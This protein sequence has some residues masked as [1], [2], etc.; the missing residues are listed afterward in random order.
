MSPPNSTPAAEGYPKN[1]RW[2]AL[3]ALGLAWPALTAPETPRPASVRQPKS[4]R[5]LDRYGDPLPPGA[6]ARMGTTFFRHS[7]WTADAVFSPDGKA[8]IS[9]GGDGQVRLWSVATGKERAHFAVNPQ[10]VEGLALSPDG[11]TLAGIDTSS[12]AY[13]WQV[14]TGKELCRVKK[15]NS[16]NTRIAFTPKGKPVAMS[17]QGEDKLLLWEMATGKVLHRIQGIPQWAV[18]SPGAEIV[19]EKRNGTLDLRSVAT[20]RELRSIITGQEIVQRLAFSQDGKTLASSDADRVV[21]IW[22]IS[23]AKK[24]G[25]LPR[26]KGGISSL[27]FAPN[28]K[29]L[30][31]ATGVTRAELSNRPR[32]TTLSFWNWR[33]GKLFRRFQAHEEGAAHLTLSRDGKLLAVM[34]ESP[35]RRLWDLA[36]GKELFP[37]PGNFS[38]VTAPA[39][40]PDSKLLASAGRGHTVRLWQTGTGKQVA[41]LPGHGPGGTV[42]AF[43][44]NGKTLATAGREKT[45]RLWNVTKKKVILRLRGH[46]GG[47]SAL[48]F[49]PDGKQLVSGGDYSI[50]LWSLATAKQLRRFWIISGRYSFAVWF[51]AFTPDGKQVVSL[52]DRCIYVWDLTEGHSLWN[53]GPFHFIALSP[54]GK[55]VGGVAYNGVIF[56]DTGTGK[57]TGRLGDEETGG[58]PKKG[59]KMF[60]FSP[61]GKMVATIGRDYRIRF[62]E[63]ISGK[64]IARLRG[65]PFGASCLCFSPDG[66]TL[67]TGF[68]DSTILEWDVNQVLLGKRRGASRLSPAGLKKLWDD[69]AGEEVPE[70]FQALATLVAAPKTAVPFLREQLFKAHKNILRQIAD[71]DSPRYGTRRKA[72]QELKRLGP[73]AEPFLRKELDGTPSLEVR[74]RVERLLKKLRDPL[75]TPHG[76]RLL[77][78]ITVLERIGSPAARKVLKKLTLAAPGD[79]LRREA[80]ASLDRLTKQPPSRVLPTPGK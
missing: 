73:R 56:L 6:I 39:Y 76:R 53:L 1:W 33:T 14:S 55:E 65:H 7:G 41:R 61:D 19:V 71:L 9:S 34:A 80:R 50:R 64:K 62:W 27:A 38:P 45:I 52:G 68:L 49:S 21:K 77:R 3:F 35:T 72:T 23:T 67:A 10:G 13:L 51:V 63:S 75:R 5:P 43:S 60:A 22:E 46:Q 47:V 40:S 36:T 44:P 4:R 18:F 29:V 17:F 15:K 16:W 57:K 12:Q 31:V 11:K 37:R 28:G 74:Q 25:Q 8:L 20:G 24:L 26:I 30:I 48:G 58:N 59:E 2:A 79:K 66:K 42:V 69:L 78:A 70:A 54:D 32:G